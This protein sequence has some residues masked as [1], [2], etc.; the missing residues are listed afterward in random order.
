MEI[1]TARA[2]YNFVPFSNRILWRYKNAQQ[3]PRH[4]VL[5]ARLLT[6]EIQVTITAQTPVYISNSD[7]SGFITNA[8]GQYMVPGST[9][10][11]LIRQNMQILGFGLIRA[12]EDMDDFRL[13]Y[14]DMTSAKDA[15]T[16]S[17]RNRYVGV[18]GIQTRKT[19]G[20]KRYS[21]AASVKGGYL[22]NEGGKYYIVPAKG[23]VLSVSRSSSLAAKW[24]DKYAFEQPV[25]YQAVGETVTDIQTTETEQYCKGVLLIPGLMRKQNRLYIFPA[26]SADSA[27]IMLSDE[28]VLSYQEDV[29]AKRNGLKGTDKAYPMDPRFWDMPKRG[30]V[31]AVF[32]VTGDDGFTS[33]G[34][35]QFLRLAYAYSLGHGL[36]ENHQK[37]KDSEQIDYPFAILGYTGKQ[38]SY[39]SR[40]S[41]GDL[42]AQ[43][44]PQ[45]AQAVPIVLG[46]PKP[47]F[48]AGYTKNGADYNQPDFQ[49]N[50]FKQYWLQPL[51][52]TGEATKLNVASSIAPLPA[53]TQFTGTICYRNLHEDELGLLLW[54][55][56]LDDGCYQNIGSGKPYGFGR[57]KIQ[58]DALRE[59]D[60]TALYT[61]LNAGAQEQGRTADR[62]EEL[63]RAYDRYACEKFCYSPKKGQVSLRRMS[64][65]Q[66]FL[67]LKSTIRT[68]TKEVSYM[69]LSEHRNIQA[70]LPTVAFIR[71]EQAHQASQIQNE[72][73]PTDWKAM[74][75][76]KNAQNAVS[77]TPAKKKKGGW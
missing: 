42:I 51:R 34:I 46:S 53:G 32:Y 2:P 37:L 50:G 5:E 57:V 41:A 13:M 67:Y 4:D 48:M 9:L 31:K 24:A 12:E 10:R 8:R 23:D 38:E 62:V 18:L 73:A 65:I 77:T 36:P 39:R 69:E 40:V 7:R 21:V 43:N 58:I 49:L 61:R 25:W 45:P 15:L 75:A 66:D 44:D 26:E 33:F 70:P 16:Y 19:P 55:L 11:G 71:K 76:K 35:S 3:L 64:H 30:G 52:E 14:R 1:K 54:C 6:G 59:F 47:S 27:P 68:D 74:L 17:L 63:I 28:E 29:E 72:P 20:G 22:H 60:L 56:R